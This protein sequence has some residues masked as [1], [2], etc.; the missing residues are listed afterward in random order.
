[1]KK[2]TGIVLF[3]AVIAVVQITNAQSRRIP[4]N[5]GTGKTN[6]RA[7]TPTPTPT[8]S[9]TAAQTPEPTT[10]IPDGIEEVSG[11]ESIETRLVTLPIRVIDRKGRFVGGVGKES[12][13]VFEDNVEQEIAHFSNEAEPFTVALVLDMSYSAKFKLTDI[14]SA[15]IAFIDQLKPNDRVMVISFAEEVFVNCEPT[16]DRREIHRA[17]RSTQIAPGT[18]LYEAVNLT[19]ND[20]LRAIEGRK[21]I[22]M[23][24]D[25][26]DT[27]SRTSHDLENLRDAM[28]L[29]ALIYPIRYDTF[30]DVQAMKNRPVISMPDSRPKGT[31]PISPNG[32][33]I[34]TSIPTGPMIGTPSDKGTTVEEYRRG[35]EYLDQLANRTGGRLYV[36][37]TIGNMNAA[38]SKIASELREFYSI[39]Y[40]PTGDPEPGKSVRVKVR[41]DRPDVAVKARTG[42]TMGRRKAAK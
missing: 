5:S 18:S 25:G 11:V 33:Q 23:F 26:V 41:V 31:P 9:S 12:F 30:E 8:P 4:P 34:P 29:D 1:M 17:I 14:Q 19:M 10:D 22:V 38:Y 32:T 6:Q 15:A 28:E 21:A 42:Y 3:V 2:I 37:D 7:T 35:E 27:T 40:Y 24:T 13:K 20:R 16:S 39:G 36:A